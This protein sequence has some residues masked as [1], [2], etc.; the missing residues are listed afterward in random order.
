MIGGTP[1]STVPSGGIWNLCSLRH[2]DRDRQCVRRGRRGVYHAVVCV[3]P[4]VGHSARL[5]PPAVASTDFQI[6]PG[7]TAEK[8]WYWRRWGEG[9]RER[10]E[11]REERGEVRR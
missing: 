5:C 7:G 2:S 8:G 4:A 3:P 9:G 1:F 10:K 6:P 11:R